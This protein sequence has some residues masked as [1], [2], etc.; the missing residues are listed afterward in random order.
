VIEFFDTRYH[1]ENTGPD[2]NSLFV[3]QVA[4]KRWVGKGDQILLSENVETHFVVAKYYWEAADIARQLVEP[5]T[6]GNIL[7]NEIQKVTQ[8]GWCSA[9]VRGHTLLRGN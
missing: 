5:L 8:L 7:P 2:D 9:I 4:I 1:P 3:Y 6:E